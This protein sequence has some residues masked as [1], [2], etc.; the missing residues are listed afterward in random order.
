MCVAP[1]GPFD[2]DDAASSSGGGAGRRQHGGGGVGDRRGL[3][4]GRPDPAA[5][6]YGLVIIIVL[7]LELVGISQ[8]LFVILIIILNMGWSHRW[9]GLR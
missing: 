5:E 6:F 1:G 2:G 8:D 7:D 9:C 4:D 3:V